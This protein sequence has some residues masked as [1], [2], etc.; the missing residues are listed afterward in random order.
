MGN[1]EATEEE[2]ASALH[3]AVADFV[4]D[5]P[6]GLDTPCSESGGGFSEGQAQRISI[7]RGLLRNGRVMILDEPTS[8]LDKG[9]E[10]TLLSRLAENSYGKTM[11]IVS[12]SD[13]VAGFCDS[14]IRLE[15]NRK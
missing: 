13:T 8:A 6:D 15:R 14:I 2:M 7:A 5:L 3:N 1:P 9:T 4:L 12:H 11:I 10:Q